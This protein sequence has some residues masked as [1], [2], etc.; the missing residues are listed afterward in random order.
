M[1]VLFVCCSALRNAH[2]TRFMSMA[3]TMTRCILKKKLNPMTNSK[4]VRA[5]TAPQIQH[6]RR[7]N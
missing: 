2:L 1:M 6:K 7:V 4:K 3:D 5:L